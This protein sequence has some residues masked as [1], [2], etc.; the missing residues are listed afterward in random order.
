MKEFSQ[1][2]SSTK[3]PV[4]AG[5]STIATTALLGAALLKLAYQVSN[6]ATI[7]EERLNKIEENL[8]NYID[9]D[10]IAFKINQNKKFKDPESLKE[11][12]DIPLH[13]AQDSKIALSMG[14][15]IREEIK[16]SVKADYHISILNLKTSIKGAIKIIES[17]YQF[18]DNNNYLHQVQNKIKNIK[19]FITTEN[20]K[21]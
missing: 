4:P 8:L 14:L 16:E 6:I 17:N 1:L 9:K 10:V 11:I 3:N 7:E 12:I 2:I 15:A 18:F 21:I 20:L 19:K 13:I 5:G